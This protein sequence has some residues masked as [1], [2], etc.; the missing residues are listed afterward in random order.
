MLC[1][2]GDDYQMHG[3]RRRH[4]RAT[5]LDAAA[6]H[7]VHRETIMADRPTEAEISKFLD[8]LRAYRATIPER[9]QEML[10][11]M[12]LGAIRKRT[13]EEQQEVQSYWAAVNP[14]GPVG[15]YGAGGVAVN[16]YGPRGGPGAGA[17]V[18]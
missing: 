8:G 16:P 3:L 18:W 6:E 12:V 5:R 2:G 15:G 10:D 1:I 14:V 17:V 7:H 9:Q 4:R 11:V 13:E